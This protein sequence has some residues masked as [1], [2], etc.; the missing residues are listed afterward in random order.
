MPTYQYQCQ[1]CGF[2]FERFQSMNDEP[3]KRCP[4]CRCKVKRLI[5]TGAG[6]IFKGSGFYET[7][8]RSESY[9]KGKKSDEGKDKASSSESSSSESKSKSE[10]PSKKKKDNTAKD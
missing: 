3:V 8:Y 7:D 9:E 4:E 2:E 6:I 10:S 1:S 5:G